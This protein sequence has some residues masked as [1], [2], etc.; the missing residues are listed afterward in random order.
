MNEQSSKLKLS[1][2]S[3]KSL[4]K[5]TITHSY[6]H[7]EN[8]LFQSV[9]WP[10]LGIS[11]HEYISA[12]GMAMEVAEKEDFSG[13]LSLLHHQLGMVINWIELG[14][15]ANPLPIQILADQGT[16]VVAHDYAVRVQHRNDLEHI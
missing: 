16:S 6:L 10:S 11:I 8:S 14:A 5:V 4:K 3:E 15:R 12:G 2:F 7:W 13:L 9:T 1:V